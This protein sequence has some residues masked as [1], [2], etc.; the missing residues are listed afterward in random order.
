MQATFQ[1][2]G[3]NLK[4]AFLAFDDNDDGYISGSEFRRGIEALRVSVSVRQIEELLRHFDNDGDDRISY[5]EF[6]KEFGY[7]TGYNTGGGGGG[8]GRGGRHRGHGRNQFWEQ[9]RL[10]E[11]QRLV[12]RQINTPASSNHPSQSTFT[13]LVFKRDVLRRQAVVVARPAVQPA[14]QVEQRHPVASRLPEPA[15]RRLHRPVC[16]ARAV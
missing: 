10:T 6:E 5:R 11:L 2:A 4:Q 1:E 15:E 12:D 9:D 13:R 7:D 16:R 3:V 14:R 8:G